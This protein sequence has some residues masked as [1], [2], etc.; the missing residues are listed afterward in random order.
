MAEFSFIQRRYIIYI[1]FTETACNSESG[2][3]STTTNAIYHTS[4]A[5]LACKERTTYNRLHRT[6][7]AA[8]TYPDTRIGM[9]LMALAPSINRTHINLW[10][11]DWSIHFR[12]MLLL[13][14]CCQ[15]ISFELGL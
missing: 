5:G 10:K 14:C 13:L 2:Q 9:L 1:R 11:I 6:R 15:N 7:V 8:N 4:V 3:S 12:R